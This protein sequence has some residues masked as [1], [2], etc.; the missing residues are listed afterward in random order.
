MEASPNCAMVVIADFWRRRPLAC[1]CRQLAANLW[2]NVFTRNGKH[3]GKL[4]KFTWH[5][6]K[7]ISKTAGPFLTRLL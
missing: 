1:S 3:L 7:N 5:L 2:R 4:P 6:A